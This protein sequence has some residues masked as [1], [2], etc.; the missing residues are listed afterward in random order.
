MT[1]TV[2]GSVSSVRQRVQGVVPGYCC[3][4]VRYDMTWAVRDHEHE[5]DT[6]VARSVAAGPDSDLLAVRKREKQYTGGGGYSI[7]FP[8][9]NFQPV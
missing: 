6:I 2:A 4:P 9:K 7:R 3:Q 1:D 8:W 5:Q